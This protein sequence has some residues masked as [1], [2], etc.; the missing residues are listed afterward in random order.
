MILPEAVCGDLVICYNRNEFHFR[1][2]RFVDSY[3]PERVEPE[4]ADSDG[5]CHTAKDKVPDIHGCT[6][7]TLAV[8]IS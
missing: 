1:P 4:V 5:R 3:F 8:G 2:D 7:A 6:L